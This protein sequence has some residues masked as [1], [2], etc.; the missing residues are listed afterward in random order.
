MN[1]TFLLASRS[2][3][4]FSRPPSRLEDRTKQWRLAK[5]YSRR[6]ST[7]FV[8]I[9]PL[10]PVTRMQSFGEA[11][12]LRFVMVQSASKL[13]AQDRPPLRPSLTGATNRFTL[14][15]DAKIAGRLQTTYQWVRVGVR[16]IIEYPCA[17]PPNIKR[18]L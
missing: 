5:P 14:L 7:T 16:L 6:I 13:Q 8:P 11:M 9:K 2:L 1:L 17:A 3:S 18:A 12:D 10:D 15:A 4:A